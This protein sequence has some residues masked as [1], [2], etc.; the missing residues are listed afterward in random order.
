L[1]TFCDS[2]WVKVEHETKELE[3]NAPALT[4]SGEKGMAISLPSCRPL[5][6]VFLAFAV[7]CQE[8]L[9]PST[10]RLEVVQ[11]QNGSK[12]LKQDITFWTVFLSFIKPD[13]ADLKRLYS[14]SVA[15]GLHTILFFRPSVFSR[16]ATTTTQPTVTLSRA[17]GLTADFT[18]F[19]VPC[20]REFL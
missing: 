2:V 11:S 17:E 19:S 12:L 7:V 13:E 4:M 5:C 14:D 6:V 8:G 9:E 10:H 15:H 16:A 18:D 20:R 1:L 3:A